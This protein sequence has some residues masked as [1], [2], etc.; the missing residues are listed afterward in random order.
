M[1]E[2]NAARFVLMNVP[3][4]FTKVKTQQDQED[5]TIVYPVPMSKITKE[6]M[7]ARYMADRLRLPS[8][9]SSDTNVRQRLLRL[10]VTLRLTVVFKQSF[11]K[12]SRPWD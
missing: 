3:V 4:Y 2:K 11:N 1:T 8:G 10:F 6:N 7:I 12:D 9:S 5:L